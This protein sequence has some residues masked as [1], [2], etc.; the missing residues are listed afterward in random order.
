MC[1]TNDPYDHTFSAH[2]DD[3]SSGGESIVLRP[4][5]LAKD[6]GHRTKDTPQQGS[7][8]LL[9]CAVLGLGG[10]YEYVLIDLEMARRWLLAGK[11]TSHVTHP[12]LKA[13][14]DRVLGLFTPPGQ[15]GPLPVLGSHDE[16]LLWQVEGYEL[17][18]QQSRGD[19]RRIHDLLRQERYT[20]GVLR[21]LA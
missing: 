2:W 14:L 11:C 7:R 8:Y 9:P 19:S 13:A 15:P 5:S 21:R 12:L 3:A 10:L 16:A 6:H 4:S 20:L 1:P 17:L 18:A